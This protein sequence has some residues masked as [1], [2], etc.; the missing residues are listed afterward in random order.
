[1]ALSHEARFLVASATKT[2]VQ[3][4]NRAKG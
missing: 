2:A 4:P 3:Q 1:M